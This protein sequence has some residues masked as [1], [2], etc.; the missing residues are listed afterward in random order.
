MD[1]AVTRHQVLRPVIRPPKAHRSRAD[2]DTAMDKTAESIQQFAE[3]VKMATDEEKL[4]SIADEL[5]IDL[6]QLEGSGPNGRIVKRDL[7][8]YLKERVT[9]IEGVE[10]LPGESLAGLLKRRGPM[11]VEAALPL[12]RQMAAAL[13]AAHEKGVIHRDMKN[14]D[15]EST[16]TLFRTLAVNG[17]IYAAVR[18][19]ERG[20]IIEP[21]GDLIRIDDNGREDVILG[22]WVD[23]QDRFEACIRVPGKGQRVRSLDIET[24]P[25]SIIFCYG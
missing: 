18:H 25:D 2:F 3:F 12:F 7:E 22:Q 11:T 19:G 16:K 9:E 5:G 14:K 13:A 6:T 17:I 4:K 15:R 23:P 24:L 10:L 21:I 8:A 20:D 1:I